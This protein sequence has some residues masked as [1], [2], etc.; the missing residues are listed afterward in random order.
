[1]KKKTLS[2]IA[3]VFAAAALLSASVSADG[4]SLPVLGKS[5]TSERTD[6]SSY[7]TP[8]ANSTTSA[9]Y[10]AFVSAKPANLEASRDRWGETVLRWDPVTDAVLYY[11][12]RKEGTSFKLV[13][14]TV[15]NFYQEIKNWSYDVP[16][17]TYYVRAVTYNYN[18]KRVMSRKSDQYTVT[19]RS[20][21]DDYYYDDEDADTYAVEDSMNAGYITSIATADNS[22]AAYEDGANYLWD[23]PVEELS[24]EEYSHYDVDGF[25]KASDTPLSTFSADVDTASYAN[26]R[27]LATDGSRITAD[28]VRIEEMLNYF[29]YN[30]QKPSKGTFALTYEYS[31][32]PWNKD[33]KLLM[34][35]LQAKDLE[36]EPASNL[37]FLVD[38]SGSMSSKDKLPLL[39]ESFKKLMNE[40]TKND[41]IS[42]VTYS[43]FENAVISGARGNM[44]NCIADIAEALYADGSTNGEAG[45]NMAYEIAKKNYIKDGNNRVILATDGDLNVGISDKDELSKF[46]SEKRDTGVYMTVLGFG[47]GNIKD[48]K[49]EALAKDGNGNYH[50]IDCAAEA[51]KVLVDERKK[52]LVTVADDVKIQVEFNPT[53]VD[54]YKLIGY[55]GRK[56]NNED[57][58][59][60]AKDA[61]DMGAGQSITVLY[62]IIP[63]KTAANTLTYQTS[64]NNKT[65]ICTMKVRFKKPGETK[66]LQSKFT[67]KASEYL[68]YAKTDI[69]FRFATCVAEAAMA[70]KN[71]DSYGEVSLDSAMSRFSK[72]GT[73]ELA[74]VGYSDDFASLLELL[75]S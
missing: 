32:C 22:V 54:S 60:D 19:N 17:G 68:G 44:K 20:R 9:R 18:D 13:G 28:A 36:K 72:L 52:T 26:V 50:Y 5:V 21:Y 39:V 58:T 63:A 62:E 48:N 3:A 69:R 47:T 30:Y 65:D 33:A 43:G 73:K 70:L 53:L 8:M 75:K 40:T 6:T 14:K 38:V 66:S 1:M 25:K 11:V 51:T 34:L 16:A 27:R 64:K 15:N 49:M 42:I 74:A 57:F 37:V 71:E 59:N 35:G 4:L 46:I 24:D 10:K 41:R 67:V 23:E 2:A 55:D 29:D 56:L 7:T 45:I 61:A 12:Y 31:D